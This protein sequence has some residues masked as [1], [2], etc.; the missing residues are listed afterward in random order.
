MRDKN[1]NHNKIIQKLKPQKDRQI[2]REGERQTEEQADIET[3]RKTDK[4]RKRVRQT[5]KVILNCTDY[6]SLFTEKM[7]NIR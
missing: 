6:L 1:Q 7:Y 3:G 5:F 4:D 2:N